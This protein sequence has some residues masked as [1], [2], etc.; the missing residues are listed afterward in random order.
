MQ[1]ED[2]IMRDS[3]VWIKTV[4]GLEKVD[5]ILRRVDDTF[6]DPLEL[7][8]DSQLG[9]PGLLQAVRKGNV[10]VANPLGS[11][12][13]ENTGLMAFLHGAFKY[14]LNEDPI[15]PMIATWWCGQKKEMDYVLEHLD[16]LVIKDIERVSGF[17]TVMGRLLSKAQKEELIRKIKFEPFRYVGQEEVEFSTSPVFTKGKLEP[18]FSVLR[19]YLVANKEGYDPQLKNMSRKNFTQPDFTV[20]ILDQ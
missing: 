12:I 9:I 19:S 8:E 15:I 20:T 6:C 4:E 7:R 10:A 16:T 3:F 1:G 5:I 13:L 11:S 18:R 17:K 2:L 14:F